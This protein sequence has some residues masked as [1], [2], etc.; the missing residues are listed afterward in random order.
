ME[1]MIPDLRE[2][3]KKLLQAAP[4]HEDLHSCIALLA[5]C[6][7][8][9]PS[10]SSVTASW[11]PRDVTLLKLSLI[12]IL[13]IKADNLCIEPHVRCQYSHVLE[14]LQQAGIE[15]TIIRLLNTS[16]KVLSHIASKCLSYLVLYQ[17]KYQ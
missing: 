3:H 11:V 10:K 5:P 2:L 14:L 12:Q 17:L 7:P 8:G 6:L 9:E 15:A 4:L 16:D 13:V 1:G